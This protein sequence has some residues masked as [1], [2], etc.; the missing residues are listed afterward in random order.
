MESDQVGDHPTDFPAVF[1]KDLANGRRGHFDAEKASSAERIERM[2]P[3]QVNCTLDVG[4]VRR[5]R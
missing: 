3:S 4:A 1:L 5:G 2:Q